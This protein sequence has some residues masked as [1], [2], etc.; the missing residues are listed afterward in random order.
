MFLGIIGSD[1]SRR[2]TCDNNVIWN[3]LIDHY[4]INSNDNVIPDA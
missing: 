1:Y 2:N 4:T 3:D